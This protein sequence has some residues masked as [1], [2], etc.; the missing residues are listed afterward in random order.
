MSKIYLM[1]QKI[2]SFLEQAG[3]EYLITSNGQEAV[4]VITQGA[5]FGCRVDGLHDASHDAI[6]A[7]RVTGSGASNFN[8]RH[9]YPLLLL[10][11]SVLEED[12]KDCFDAGMNAYLPKP[13]KSHQLYDLFSSS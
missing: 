2:A 8:K 10:T 3:Y 6:T 9:H 12:I 11:A 4:D 5:Q 1:N 13:Y 7:T